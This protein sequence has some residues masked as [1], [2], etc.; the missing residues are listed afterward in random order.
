MKKF[1]AV[2]LLTV[3]LIL[4]FS[5]ALEALG[6]AIPRESMSSNGHWLY[7]EH[8]EK[9]GCKSPGSDCFWS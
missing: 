9:V 8:G 4:S 7:N 3:M 1:L 6:G 2:S 5:L